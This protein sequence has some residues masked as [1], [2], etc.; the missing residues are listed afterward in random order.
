MGERY[1]DP[2]SEKINQLLYERAA[3][4]MFPLLSEPGPLGAHLP[5]GFSQGDRPKLSDERAEIEGIESPIP[6]TIILSY[7]IQ[8]AVISDPSRHPREKLVQI[9]NQVATH[10]RVHPIFREAYN[11]LEEK[12]DTEKGKTQEI[13]SLNPNRAEKWLHEL[14]KNLI[15]IRERDFAGKI[16]NALCRYSQRASAIVVLLGQG[17]L[18]GSTTAFRRFK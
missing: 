6:Y 1:G 9:L 13:T 14:H 3:A 17:H 16:S 10:V 12:E 5:W 8:R 18:Q 7:E 4:G 2:S 11:K 15:D